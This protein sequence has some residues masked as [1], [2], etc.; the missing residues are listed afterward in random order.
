MTAPDA[1]HELYEQLAVGH[2][3]AALEPEDEVAFL[4]HLP[5]CAA[6][7]RALAE[8]TETLAHLAYGVEDVDPPASLLDGIRSGVEASGESGSFPAPLPLEIA[9]QRRHR[10]VRATTALLGVAASLVLVVGL[11]F[12]NQGLRSE[13][14]DVL[15]ND[16]R[17]TSAVSN[18][19]RPGAR[20]VDLVGTGGEHVV[21]VVNHGGRVSLVMEGLP[22][23]DTDES[24]YVL[25]ERSE[26]GA[27]SAVGTFDV[28]DDD[29][30]VVSDLQLH[31]GVDAL[32]RLMVTQEKGRTA[33]PVA[34]GSLVAAGD[35]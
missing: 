31:I 4:A 12:A 30:A 19:L 33:P 18:L 29:L 22:A 15:A 10:T 13:K 2:A 24:V 21:A 16:A 26:L 3:L 32:D 14:E 5:G 27:V 1:G 17:L 23:N 28:A 11:V 25:W 8:H 20:T 35:A 7:E 34:Q 6:C 9:R